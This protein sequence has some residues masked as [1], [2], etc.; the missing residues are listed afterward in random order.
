MA[1]E[2]TVSASASFSKG[3]A[4]DAQRTISKQVDVAGDA[5][6]IKVLSIGTS[7]ETVS[8]DDVATPGFIIMKNLDSTNYVEYSHASGAY[9]GQMKA[10]EPA[11]L[12][13]TGG[14]TL[15]MSANTAA[16]LVE[17]RCYSN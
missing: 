15:H 1:N 2:L 5:F 9:L 16:C 4:Q 17:I 11:L 10:G 8:F 12:R 13:L 3:G 6:S 14:A 7:D